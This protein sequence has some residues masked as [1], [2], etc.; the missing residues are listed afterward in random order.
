MG[1]LRALLTG[2]DERALQ[3]LNK[4]V[5]GNAPLRGL[6]GSNKDALKL[7]IVRKCM[8]YIADAINKAEPQVINADGEVLRTRRNLPQ[9]IRNPSP[10]FRLKELVSQG[11][12]ST[13][14]NGDIRLLG[15]VSGN[16]V[17]T[18]MYVGDET[19][20]SQSGG[21]GIIYY[22]AFTEY[23]PDVIK[24][25][26]ISHVRRFA[27]PGTI[28]G[29]SEFDSA[30]LLLSASLE[31]HEVINNFFAQNM[32]L[33]LMFMHEGQAPKGAVENLLLTLARRHAGSRRAYVPL[34]SDRAWKVERIRD[35]NQGNQLVEL[36]R[37]LNQAICTEV[38]GIDPLVFALG[39]AST[40]GQ[41][42][43]YQNASNLR[44]QVWLQAVEPVAELIADAIS[45]F[46]PPGQ[47]LEFSPRDML[48]GSPND[49][50]QLVSSMAAAG[51]AYGSPIFTKEEIREPLGYI[52][53]PPAELDV[54]AAP[55]TPAEG[56]DVDQEFEEIVANAGI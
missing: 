50:A 7:P 35:S 26:K 30:K 32:H 13:F 14:F 52:G 28:R 34:V 4:P 23:G 27:A 18:A 56:A 2:A 46:L 12:Y 11:V 21:G 16:N 37:L 29:L 25:N 44:S 22:N 42:L 33:D 48:R 9:F 31:C 47:F 53:P 19:I 5:T 36:W 40:S 6:L 24:A 10:E 17:T 43:T 51:Q 3:P 15:R 20:V 41:T 49:R 55:E 45:D 8:G 1:F 38:F 39:S 54:V